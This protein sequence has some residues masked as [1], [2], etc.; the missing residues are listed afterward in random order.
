MIK[1]IKA[2]QKQ[3]VCE[4]FVVTGSTA[5]KFFGLVDVTNDL[6]IILVNPDE[7]TVRTLTAYQAAY[8]AETKPTGRG[9][10][11]YVF[12]DGDL[13]IDVFVTTKKV[14]TLLMVEGFFVSTVS[15]IVAAKKSYGRKKDW[16]QLVAMR[17]RIITVDEIIEAKAK[18]A[19]GETP[20][21]YEEESKAEA[22][23]KNA[24]SIEHLTTAFSGLTSDLKIRAIERLF[25]ERAIAAVPAVDV[26]KQYVAI[27]EDPV[28][29]NVGDRYY[30]RLYADL[31]KL[32]FLPKKMNT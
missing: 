32:K 5:L 4:Q 11:S 10:V 18:A 22:E 15:N 12:M 30:D 28:L 2:Y 25:T 23:A 20:D 21:E 3:F 19:K 8:P 24:E 13:K 9:A 27:G 1:K 26:I 6:D 31:L 29:S 7:V 14:D 16:Y 17:S